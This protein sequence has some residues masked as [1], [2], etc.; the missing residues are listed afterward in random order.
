MKYNI[1]TLI[2]LASFTAFSTIAKDSISVENSEK[3]EVIVKDEE[4]IKKNNV[5][6]E[7]NSKKQ[8]KTVSL[9]DSNFTPILL[10]S[11]KAFS[12]TA[13]SSMPVKNP[14]KEK[15][16][17]ENNKTSHKKT[18]QTKNS[19]EKRNVIK[20]KEEKVQQTYVMSDSLRELNPMNQS[21][22]DSL[23]DSIEFEVY[24]VSENSQ[25]HTIFMSGAGVCRGYSADGV[26]IT[27]S[28]TYYISELSD[29]EY[30]ANIARGVLNS[31]GDTKNLQY[32]SVFNISDLERSKQVKDQEAQYGKD[33]A[34]KNLKD[35]T[36]V[37]SK[38]VC[39]R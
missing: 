30:Y 37:L 38:V 12:D 29:D 13:K 16:V 21:D 32:A 18:K 7:L 11:F 25:I 4:A 39:K 27:D 22:A 10:N 28:A 2:F 5:I 9:S 36:G 3:K 14:E 15:I 35:R 34:E 23:A 31:K 1:F 33:I 24:S 20:K 17:K 8:N 6:G 26:D 19:E